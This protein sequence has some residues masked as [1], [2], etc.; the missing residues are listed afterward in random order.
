M[1]EL[2]SVIYSEHCHHC[3]YKTDFQLNNPVCMSCDYC[4]VLKKH[5]NFTLKRKM[6]KRDKLSGKG[7][8]DG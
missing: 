2:S 4:K 6:K 3:E 7:E 8:L 1:A 5:H